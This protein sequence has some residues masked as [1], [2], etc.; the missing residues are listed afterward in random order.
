MAEDMQ[1]YSKNSTENYNSKL[2][3]TCSEQRS[4]IKRNAETLKDLS[5][6]HNQNHKDMDAQVAIRHNIDQL[7][8]QQIDYKMEEKLNNNLDKL[9]NSSIEATMTQFDQ[10]TD[11]IKVWHDDVLSGVQSD[12]LNASKSGI[13][14]DNEKLRN[15]RIQDT[16][17]EDA[18][19]DIDNEWGELIANMSDDMVSDTQKNLDEMH[20]M[21]IEIQ[22]E[23]ERA[24]TLVKQLSR[25]N[26]IAYRNDHTVYDESRIP[27]TVDF[28]AETS[29]ELM[30]K[31]NSIN[32]HIMSLIS[33]ENTDFFSLE[34]VNGKVHMIYQL[35]NARPV[36]LIS[37]INVFN[38][39]E[40]QN[41]YQIN[42]KRSGS[43]A[44]LMIN[45]HGD[46]DVNIVKGTSIDG[47]TYSRITRAAAKLF[48]GGISTISKPAGV[49]TTE[50]DIDVAHF[51][52]NDANIYLWDFADKSETFDKS[53]VQ[54]NIDDVALDL[55]AESQICEDCWQFS[56]EDSWVYINEET[57][58]KYLVNKESGTIMFQLKLKAPIYADG[59]IFFIGD[60]MQ[61]KYFIAMEL[62]NGKPQFSYNLGYEKGPKIIAL[63]EDQSKYIPTEYGT[64]PQ[65]QLNFRIG[66]VGGVAGLAVQEWRSNKVVSV[67]NDFW[68]KNADSKSQNCQGCEFKLVNEMHFGGLKT[69]GRDL[70]HLAPVLATWNK[71]YRGC[72]SKAKINHQWLDLSQ[73]KRSNVM[74]GCKSEAISKISLNGAEMI[75]RDQLQTSLSNFTSTFAISLM[76][77]YPVQ[78]ATILRVKS[79]NGPNCIE[80]GMEKDGTNTP[81][82]YYKSNV[83]E[84]Q[85]LPI[86][87]KIKADEEVQITIVRRDGDNVIITIGDNTPIKLDI[88]SMGVV[89]SEEVEIQVG[90]QYK[91]NKV[92]EGYHGCITSLYVN[93]L[94]HDDTVLTSVFDGFK[95]EEGDNRDMPTCIGEVRFNECF[96]NNPQSLVERPVRNEVITVVRDNNDSSSPRR[97]NGRRGKN[98]PRGKSCPNMVPIDSLEANKYQIGKN[99]MIK[100]NQRNM[101]SMFQQSMKLELRIDYKAQGSLLQM[102]NDDC[103]ESISLLIIENKVRLLVNINDGHL[104]FNTEKE[105]PKN[106]NTDIILVIKPDEKN[107]ERTKFS[108]TVHGATKTKKLRKDMKTTTIKSLYIGRSPDSLKC[109]DLH[110]THSF[111]GFFYGASLNGVE[112]RKRRFENTPS[113][114][115]GSRIPGIFLGKRGTVI[116]MPLNGV[117]VNSLA[118]VLRPRQQSG[119]IFNLYSR[120]KGN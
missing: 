87:N 3:V 63:D 117:Q 10:M 104:I 11:D 78:D 114:I 36:T 61:T 68:L 34:V 37:E 27:K 65:K 43:H 83:D 70:S 53:S 107:P 111:T 25:K 47:L 2:T 24:R 105:I 101:Q 54:L 71:P 92:K 16:K 103:T 112:L 59:L 35:G 120:S 76:A 94:T 32:S 22:E 26:D 91:N 108:I 110:H 17:L 69:L 89:E 20:V 30:L 5:E 84:S 41:W 106:T 85:T 33:T 113:I 42:A 8:D 49:S 56:G 98:R 14:T 100:L 39:G 60:P 95:C 46:D 99:S 29:V 75:K 118:F 6:K 13:Q 1:K 9:R 19:G 57:H 93:E 7:L 72:M 90:G 21:I 4:A 18:F 28:K 48:I 97:G 66:M 102:V 116:D 23:I 119:D 115:T 81:I 12:V 50:S 55:P 44:I 15:M 96:T 45:K 52:L 73:T 109:A 51:I 80:F 58:S 40:T 38:D 82:F 74:V 86:Q 67:E 88:N 62:V 77:G 64:L 79:V 31:A